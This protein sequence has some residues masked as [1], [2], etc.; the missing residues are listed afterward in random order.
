ML[1]SIVTIIIIRLWLSQFPRVNGKSFGSLAVC[2]V[3]DEEEESFVS[4]WRQPPPPPPPSFSRLVTLARNLSRAYTL[5]CYVCVFWRINASSNITLISYSPASRRFACSLSLSLRAL[6]I[7]KK[8]DDTCGA[9]RGI[10][11]A[12]A[13]LYY[14]I[15]TPLAACT[16]QGNT[17]KFHAT[18]QIKLCLDELN[19]NLTMASA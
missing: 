10:R 19:D 7:I 4:T 15:H 6:K 13:A 12:A 9:Q 5:R 3:G 16:C 18:W 17:L 2:C 8:V 14:N 11:E 1:Y